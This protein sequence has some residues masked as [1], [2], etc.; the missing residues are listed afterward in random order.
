MAPAPCVPHT[1]QRLHQYL[2]YD[3]QL[4]GTQQVVEYQ[5]SIR[6]H[7]ALI[8]YYASAIGPWAPSQLPRRQAFRQPALLFKK[9]DESAVEEGYAWIAS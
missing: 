6:S 3:G 7:L 1:A 8:C 9:L 5:E 2:G 4:F